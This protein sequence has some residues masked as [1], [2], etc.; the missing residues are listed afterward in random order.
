MMPIAY[1]SEDADRQ[2][3]TQILRLKGEMGF[4]DINLGVIGK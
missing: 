1:P 2:L 4:R 3:D